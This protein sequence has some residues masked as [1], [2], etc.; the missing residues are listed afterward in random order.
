MFHH[1]IEGLWEPILLYDGQAR[2]FVMHENRH[3][4]YGCTKSMSGPR[5]K[6]IILTD[7]ENA[8]PEDIPVLQYLLNGL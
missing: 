1:A 6:D 8:G 4:I 2:W 7:S 5:I 3:D